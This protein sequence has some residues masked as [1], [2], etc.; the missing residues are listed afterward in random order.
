M[1]DSMQVLKFLADVATL[2][3][4]HFGGEAP[5]SSPPAAEPEAPPSSSTTRTSSPEDQEL[6]TS[7]REVIAGLMGCSLCGASGRKSQSFARGQACVSCLAS[8]APE[9]LRA[10]HERLLLAYAAGSDARQRDQQALAAERAASERLRAELVDAKGALAE[11]LR[12]HAPPT[13]TRGRDIE[14]EIEVDF[15]QMV[16]GATVPLRVEVDGQLRSFDVRVPPGIGDGKKLGLRGRGGAGDPPGDI[17][18]TVRV[19]PH[20]YLTRVGNDIVMHVSVPPDALARNHLSV[21]T[22]SGPVTMLLT[23]ENLGQTLRFK[24]KG[25][26]PADGEA[27]DLLLTLAATS[28]LVR[29][30]DASLADS[31]SAAAGFA[32][33][34]SL[35]APAGDHLTTLANWSEDSSMHREIR[36]VLWALAIAHERGARE[37]LRGHAAQLI[38]DL[39]AQGLLR[40]DGPRTRRSR[41][42]AWLNGRS[43]LVTKEQSSAASLV[44]WKVH[45]EYLADSANWPHVEPRTI[46][47]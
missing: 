30:S 24:A 10:A 25:I 38:D 33:L 44:L 16:C 6:I 14:A 32:S 9:A 41:V 42:F 5:S 1:M 36:E 11:V 21:E 2:A 27:G 17:I 13:R 12:Q 31:P 22:P 26:A 23:P 37:P 18:V 15:I 39:V 20:P 28:A 43:P 19:L 34:Q 46:T 47:H 45:L 7:I 40:P 3:A 29:Q 35:S 8:A 4:A